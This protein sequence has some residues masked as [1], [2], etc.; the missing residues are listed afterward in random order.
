MWNPR[1][2]GFYAVLLFL[3]KLNDMLEHNGLAYVILD[4]C[5]FF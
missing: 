2:E 1:G 4:K 3:E 5:S